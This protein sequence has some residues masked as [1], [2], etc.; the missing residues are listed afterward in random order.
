MASIP[1][2]I[3]RPGRGASLIDRE[4]APAHLRLNPCA[5]LSVVRR[6]ER[7]VAVTVRAPVRGESLR[8]TTVL[9]EREPG[10]VKH[11]ACLANA[12]QAG[13]GVELDLTVAQWGRL[14]AAGFLL[15]EEKLPRPVRFHCSLPRPKNGLVPRRLRVAAPVPTRPRR[16][17]VPWTVRTVSDASSFEPPLDAARTWVS[18]E[19]PSVAVPAWYALGQ[20]EA[21]IVAELRPGEPPPPGL[22]PALRARLLEAGLIQD[23]SAARRAERRWARECEAAAAKAST[24]RYVVL[25]R[26]LHPWFAAAMRRYYRQ[27]VAQGAVQLGDAQNERRFMA[28]NEP[29]A[30]LVHRALVPLVA[31]IAREAVK[32]SYVY[33]SSYKGAISRLTRTA[34]SVNSAC[35]SSSTTGPSP[36]T[37]R[38]GL[39]TFSGTAARPGP[40]TWAWETASST[41]AAS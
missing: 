18:V 1:R 12:I 2:G 37:A 20:R 25:R 23:R 5:T 16:L 27:L 35:L 26:L 39:S 38:H 14:A 17:V 24:H 6:H 4:V 31:R 7:V 30:G 32:P 11:L 10:L 33:F 19:V 21:A 40:C 36:R 29:L 15:P 9:R 13:E 3:P 8:T 41:A 28:H 34:R 22:E